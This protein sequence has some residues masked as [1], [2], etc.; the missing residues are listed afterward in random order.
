MPRPPVPP[1]VSRVCFVACLILAFLI[2]IVYGVLLAL[3]AVMFGAVPSGF[4]PS[5]DKQYLIGVAQRPERA[6]PVCNAAV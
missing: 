6:A 4:V 5:P 3:T 2:L 1:I